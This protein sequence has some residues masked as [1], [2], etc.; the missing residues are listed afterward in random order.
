LTTADR[1]PI[2]IVMGENNIS[3]ALAASVIATLSPDEKLDLNDRESKELLLLNPSYAID[4]LKRK[5]S[6]KP[7]HDR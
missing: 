7:A 1:P 3:K 6:G 2:F 5:F 4:Y